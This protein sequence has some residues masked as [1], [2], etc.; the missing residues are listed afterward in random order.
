LFKGKALYN[1][2]K[3]LNTQIALPRDEDMP[4]AKKL[5][6]KTKF[7]A[8]PKLFNPS[9]L[10]FSLPESL[11]KSRAKPKALQPILANF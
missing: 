3:A 5:A 1:S 11:T 6:F 4:L 2:V 9:W 10:T 7:R 8:K